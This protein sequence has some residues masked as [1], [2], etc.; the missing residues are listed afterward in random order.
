MRYGSG[1]CPSAL[2]QW[3]S[4]SKVN[5]HISDIQNTMVPKF[6]WLWTKTAIIIT[7]YCRDLIVNIVFKVLNLIYLKEKLFLGT[8][9]NEPEWGHASE[10]WVA[11]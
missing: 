7:T 8:C 2:R 9:L 6:Q 5:T 11:W 10:S 4:A 3:F 1:D